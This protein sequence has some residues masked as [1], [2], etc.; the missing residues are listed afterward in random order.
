M[1]LRIISW[2][3]TLG[4]MSTERKQFWVR[5]IGRDGLELIGWRQVSAR[6][7]KGAVRKLQSWLEWESYDCDRATVEV[8]ECCDE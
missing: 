3:P 6:T 1:G 2:R 5:A 8:K 7:W 4:Q